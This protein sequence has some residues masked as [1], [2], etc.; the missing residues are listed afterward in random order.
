MT[1]TPRDPFDVAGKVVAVTG[2]SSG[3]GRHFA[4]VLAR[5]GALVIAAARRLDLLETLVQEIEDGGGR[6][7]AVRLDVTDAASIATAFDRVEEVFGPVQALV[8]NS[9]VTVSAPATEL[10]EADW[11]RVIDTNLKGAWLVSREFARRARAAKAGGAI[12]NVASVL[13]LRVAGQVSAYAV[14]KAGLVQLTAAMALELARYGIRVN[15]LAPG[16]IETELNRDFFASDAGRAMINRIPQRRL[17]RP[18]DL[19]GPLLLLASDASGF[20]TG[21][22]LAVDGGHLVGSL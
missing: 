18:E 16:Y 6:A 20:M 10:E 7:A 15:A 5:R 14:S 21:S 22:V 9:G 19:D 12:V 13:G 2:A 11:D 4:S 3:L 8:N 17:G 1:G